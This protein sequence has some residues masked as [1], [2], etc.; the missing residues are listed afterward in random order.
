[1]IAASGLQKWPAFPFES[2]SEN[3]YFSTRT[4]SATLY[5]VIFSISKGDAMVALNDLKRNDLLTAPWYNNKR[6]EFRVTGDDLTFDIDGGGT[7]RQIGINVSGLNGAF[8]PGTIFHTTPATARASIFVGRMVNLPPMSEGEA[9]NKTLTLDGKQC[10]LTAP[11]RRLHL[12]NYVVNQAQYLVP[13]SKITLLVERHLP[14][15]G[16]PSTS[17]YHVIKVKESTLRYR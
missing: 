12:K 10:I 6:I 17:Y 11:P 1:V 4:S 2:T 5:Q 9:F 13:N 14:H 16:T 15:R 7:Q 8:F 3:I